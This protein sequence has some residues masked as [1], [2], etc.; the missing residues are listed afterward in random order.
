MFSIQYKDAPSAPDYKLKELPKIIEGVQELD[1]LCPVSKLTGNRENP[2]SLLMKV[3][4]PDKANLL[5][6]IMQMIPP[7]S[8]ESRLT[9]NDRFDLVKSRL[10]TGTPSEDA[11]WMHYLASVSDVLFPAADVNQ[12]SVDSVSSDI[13][14][15]P[16]PE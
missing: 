2:L 15:Q 1:V 6:G 9:D 10:L 14:V 4:P 11:Q 16:N 8:N 12:S 5:G 7:S 13:D 3:L